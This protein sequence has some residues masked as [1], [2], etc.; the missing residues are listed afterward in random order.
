M[1]NIRNEGSRIAIRKDA[2]VSLIKD[3]NSFQYKSPLFKLI[4]EVSVEHVE[5]LLFTKVT[6]DHGHVLLRPQNPRTLSQDA[7]E[8]AEEIGVRFDV[9]QVPS[10]VAVTSVK[11]L[12]RSLL[13][14]LMVFLV[15]NAPVRRASDNEV[16]ARGRKSFQYVA[17][18][19][20]EYFLFFSREQSRLQFLL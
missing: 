15:K 18:I 20:L 6:H 1:M 11:V 10:I 12:R 13:F 2:L 14:C 19:P 7:C 8:L 17:S 9:S 3:S 4:R 16:D 5:P